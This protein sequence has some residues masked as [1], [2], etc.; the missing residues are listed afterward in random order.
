MTAIVIENELINVFE[1]TRL[2]VVLAKQSIQFVLA[3]VTRFAGVV[4]YLS[5]RGIEFS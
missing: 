1:Y 2:L 4:N 5:K 3:G